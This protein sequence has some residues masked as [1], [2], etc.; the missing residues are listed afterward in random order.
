MQAGPAATASRVLAAAGAA[1][2]RA[3]T[4]RA[5]PE[6]ATLQTALEEEAAA[7]AAARQVFPQTPT[8]E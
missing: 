7:R 4:A 8:W 3:Q 5:V 6:A 1:V 2:L